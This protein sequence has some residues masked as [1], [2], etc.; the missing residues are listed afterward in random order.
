MARTRLGFL[1]GIGL[2]LIAQFCNA[3]ITPPLPQPSWKEL[4][5][6]QQRIL[7]P[8]SGEW[9]QMEGF[10]RKKWLGIA[11]RYQ[12][13]SPDEQARMQRRMTSWAKLTPE[14]RKRARDRYLSLQKASP[15]MK[16][17]VKMKWQEYKELPEA[18]KARLKTE[19][20]SRPTPRPAPSKPMSPATA[21]A[22]P[23]APAAAGVTAPP[24]SP[25]L[26]PSPT[27]GPAVS[28]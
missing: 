24:A 10:R 2:W 8:L 18:D 21:S 14:E 13:L 17:A 23:A 1:V 25:T 19:A 7:A 12:S 3:A 26:P 15:E 27:P 28:R 6:E 4:S 5:G 11:Q 20:A 22:K 16:E 9:D